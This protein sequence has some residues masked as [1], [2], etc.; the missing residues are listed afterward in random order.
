MELTRIHHVAYVV[1]DLDDA[2]PFFTERVGLQVTVRENL[3][4]D[5][6]EALILGVGASAVELIA[7][8]VEDNGVARFLATRGPG[9]H[10][11]A[12]EVPDIE[13]AMRELAAA[14]AE[15]LDEQPR[16]GLGGHK[17]AFIHP[18]SWLGV[19]TELVEAHE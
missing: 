13:A 14:G 1:A 4:D 9:L 2:L 16:I 3:T 11:V 12:Y 17:V 6:V 18:R 19:L 15:L 7:P 8:T 10:H 5:G